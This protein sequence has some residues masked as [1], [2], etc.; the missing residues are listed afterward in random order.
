MKYNLEDVKVVEHLNWTVTF[1]NYNFTTFV[2]MFSIVTCPQDRN[3]KSNQLLHVFHQCV[4]MVGNLPKGRNQ[5]SP[6]IN[7]FGQPVTYLIFL[8]ERMFFLTPHVLREIAR[9]TLAHFELVHLWAW[10]RQVVHCTEKKWVKIYLEYETG[11]D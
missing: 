9:Q 5:L 2:N 3:C 7:F 10:P 6:S 4:N 11:G 1:H 8:A